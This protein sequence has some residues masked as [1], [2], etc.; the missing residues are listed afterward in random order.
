M[1]ISK[2]ILIDNTTGSPVTTTLMD[3]T[4]KTVDAQ[5]MLSTYT[6]LKRD[7]TNVTG[8]IGTAAGTTT[9]NGGSVSCSNV[10]GSNTNITLSNSNNDYTNDISVVFKGHREAITATTGITTAGYS[11]TNN[12]FSSNTINA[13]D[14]TNSTYYVKGVSI[15]KKTNTTKQFDISVPNGDNNLITFHYSVD[16]DGNT[17]IT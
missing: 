9:I 10:S 3:V 5:Y 4:D 12:N 11:G 6:A 13:T 7:G 15:P 2:V 8:N 1:A 14:S 17:T 16:A